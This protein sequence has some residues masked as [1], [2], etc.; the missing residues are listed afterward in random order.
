MIISKDGPHRVVGHIQ[1]NDLTGSKPENK[2]HYTICQCGGSKNK[3]FYSGNHWNI[4][5]QNDMN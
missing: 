1:L 3:P 5:F 2:E 4:N